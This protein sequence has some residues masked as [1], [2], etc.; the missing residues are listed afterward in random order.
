MS[1]IQD[2]ALVSLYG[3]AIDFAERMQTPL[4]SLHFL[5]AYFS[6]PSEAAAI[7]ESLQ[8]SYQADRKS[9]V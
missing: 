1:E 6:A 8:I 7:L 4:T 5:L 2:E 9:V 3:E